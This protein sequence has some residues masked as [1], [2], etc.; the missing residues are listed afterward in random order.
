[1]SNNDS[2]LYVTLTSLRVSTHRIPP[3]RLDVRLTRGE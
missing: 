3:R 1:M 2:L